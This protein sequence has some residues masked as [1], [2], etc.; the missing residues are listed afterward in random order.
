MEFVRA[1]LRIENLPEGS[2][3]YV[4]TN[5]TD[6]TAEKTLISPLES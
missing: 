6:V 3:F 4:L 2:T 1:R 5:N